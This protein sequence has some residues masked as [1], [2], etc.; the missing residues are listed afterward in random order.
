MLHSGVDSRSRRPLRVL[1]VED[2]ALL[3]ESMA[4]A[5]D[6]VEGL[7][8]VGHCGSVDEALELARR[9]LPRLVLLDYDL[10]GERGTR[11]LKEASEAKLEARVLVVTAWVSEEELRRLVRQGVA[12]VFLKDMPLESLVEAIHV[13]AEGGAWFDQK[14]LQAMLR[15]VEN[16]TFEISPQEKVIARCLL[17]GMSNKEIAQ[18]LSRTE[19]WVKN[20]LIR[21]YAKVGA[22]TRSEL[23]RV[24][25]ERG[26]R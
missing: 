23:V 1:I 11:F 19:T 4:R 2:H 26:W 3:R 18:Q 17:A 24:A 5:L 6:L 16:G 13:V 15:P 9:E 8:V 7:H 21:L 20:A 25:M 22:H 14:F 10:G 12:G